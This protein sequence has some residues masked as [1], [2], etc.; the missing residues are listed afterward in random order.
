MNE[1]F[2]FNRLHV[3]LNSKRVLLKMAVDMMKAFVDNYDVLLTIV[4]FSFSLF[5][6]FLLIILLKLYFN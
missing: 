1:I 5:F 6:L 3:G 2:F 4:S